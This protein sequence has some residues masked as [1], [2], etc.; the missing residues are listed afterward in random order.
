MSFDGFY[1]NIKH[2]VDGV[3]TVIFGHHLTVEYGRAPLDLLLMRHDTNVR[4][5]LLLMIM[6]VE[7]DVQYLCILFCGGLL[8]GCFRKRLVFEVVAPMDG[9]RGIAAA[10]LAEFD[11]LTYNA[12]LAFIP[13]VNLSK[14]FVLLLHA[15]VAGSFSEVY[16]YLVDRAAY[17]TTGPTAG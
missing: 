10:L 8:L 1:I 17:S 5:C 4:D 15:M 6:L 16:D 11:V 2:K 7:N 13:P 12:T 3:I 9:I 14:V